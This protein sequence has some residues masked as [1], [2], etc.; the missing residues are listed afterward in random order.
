[1]LLSPA[2]SKTRHQFSPVSTL[3]PSSGAWIAE[4]DGLRGIAVLLVVLRH[5]KPLPEFGSGVRAALGFGWAG[6][7]LFFV[8]SGFLI[9]GILVDSRGARNYYSA[10]YA[11]RALRILPLYFAVLAAYFVVLPAF[12]RARPGEQWLAPWYWLHVSN[13]QSAFGREVPTLG[14]FWSLAIEEQFY[15]FWPAV[16]AIGGVR[17]L[18]WICLAVVLGSAAARGAWMDHGY[19]KEFLYR[20]TP[21]RLEPLAMG[22]LLALAVR[23]PGIRFCERYAVWLTAAGMAL[24]A[25]S[26]WRA[27]AAPYRHPMATLGFTGIALVATGLVYRA[28]AG[29]GG[30]LARTLRWRPLRSVGKYSYAI[31]V[32]HF[33]VMALLSRTVVE[34]LAGAP[35]AVGAVLWTA[36]LMAGTGTTYLLALASWRWIESP[37]LRLKSR[38]VPLRE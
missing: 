30:V 17:G 28:C 37:F 9:T 3:I 14:H 26:W 8:L 20:L 33:P 2:A 27:G 29:G 22:G 19:S 15:L 13:W 21:F 23:G 25:W 32:L 6:V 18:P 36:A 10:F 38:F 4:L 12:G 31:Y 16:V 1:M 34:R 7:D 5:F 24:V 11:R 35:P